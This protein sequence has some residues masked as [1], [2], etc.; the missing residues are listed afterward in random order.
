MVRTLILTAFAAATLGASAQCVPNQL[1]A[2]SVYGVW[3]DTLENFAN[4][5]VGVFYS[6]TLNILVPSSASAIDPSYPSFVTIDS[7]A[8][9]QLT[10]L[11]PGIAVNCNSQTGA[12]C[13]YL[14]NQVGCGLLEGTPTQAGT[15]DITIEVTVYVNFLGTQAIPRTFTGYSITVLPNTVGI[16]DIQAVGVDK[17]RNV[18]NPFVGRTNIEFSL[19]HA[20]AATITVFNLVGKQI[21]KETVQGKAG[22]NRVPFAASNLENGIYLFHVEAGG[23]N[24]TGRMVVNR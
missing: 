18:P 19:Q 5:M 1:Y 13:T 11:P 6:D 14:A 16:G 2:D 17:A 4:G 10:G 12:P 20:T 24:S 21:W 8:M 7:V 3:P 9:N 15:F 23:S 22:N